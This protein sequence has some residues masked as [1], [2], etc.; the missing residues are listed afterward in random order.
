MGDA[1]GR[2]QR[3]KNSD[4]IEAFRKIEQTV[5]RKELDQL[6]NKTVKE[7]K[8][9]TKGKKAAYAWSGGKDSLVLGEICRMAGII[10][11][12]L[13]ICNLE[14]KV[15][16]EWIEEHKPPELSII[17][18]GQDM[19]WLAAHPQM[20]FPQDSKFAAQWFSIIQH[21]GQAKYYKENQLDMLLLGRRRADGNYVGKVSNIY[22]NKQGV[23]R[24]SPLSEWTHEQILAFIHYHSLEMPPIYEWKNGYLCG[25]HAWPARQWTGSIE[26]AWAEI[27]D[28][29]RSIVTEAASYFQSAKKFLEEMQQK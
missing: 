17:N 4:W 13:V 8:E 11:C 26:N 15:F 21:R 12:V 22:T 9:K 5:S 1:L 6:V 16:I 27:Y 29:D 14:Y 19:K 7:I 25:T 18:T 23:T 28:I 10:P 20:L 3:I 24:Y 2:K